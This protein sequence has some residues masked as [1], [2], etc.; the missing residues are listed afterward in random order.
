MSQPTRILILGG[1]FG[2]VYTALTLEKALAA[3][4]RRGEVEVGLVSRENY[5]VFQP[6]LPEVISGSIGLLDVITPIRRLCPNTNLYTRTIESIDLQHRSVQ[7]T[8]GFGT[9]QHHL[10][11]DHLVVALGN[12]TSFAGSPGLAEYALPFKYLGD[13][14]ALRNRLIH[15]LEEADIEQDPEVRRALL[16]FVVA[17]GGFSGVEAV[18]ELN[19]FV[20][21]A[22]RS[23]R[24]VMPQEIRVVLLHAGG[25]IL[26]ELPRSL[27]EF[28]QKLLMKRGVEIRLGTRLAGATMDAALLEGGDRIAT[29]TLVSTVPSAPNPLVAMLPVKKERGRILVDADLQVPEHPGL[30]AVGDCAAIRDARTGDFCPP[31]AQHAT[32]EAA[33]AAHNIAAAIKGTAKKAFAFTALGKMGALG[34]RSAVAEI[35]GIKISGFLAWW[36]WR[37]IYLMK[38]P[39]LDRKIRVATDWTLDLIL[40]PDIVQLKTEH[41]PGVRREYFEPGQVIFREG[42]RGDWLYVVTEGEVEVVKSVPGH[43]EQPVRRLGAGE[44]FGEIALVSDRARSATV[45]AVTATNLL[46]IDREAFQAMFT[47]LPPLKGFVERL[48]ASRDV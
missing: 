38:L 20:R 19:D 14:L 27:A 26:P 23:F 16:T 45:R 43:G 22:A 6:M 46:A 29:R 39:G 5:I 25:L 44:C 15:T 17:G 32:R 40:P 31:T 4:I 13:A 33:C 47:T 30:W 37:T 18:A 35:F 2:G 10:H 9:R 21:A 34:R 48:I 1:G 11:F 12:V 7:S 24:N 36:L 42:D 3:E 41:A 8:A 28:A